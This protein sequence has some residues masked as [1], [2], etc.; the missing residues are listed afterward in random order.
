MCGI[1]GIVDFDGGVVDESLLGRMC[2]AIR[3]RGPDDHGIVRLGGKALDQG[4]ASVG[5]GSRRLSII[6]IAQGQQPMTNEDRTVWVVF[7]GEIYNFADLRQV[8]EQAG[9]TFSTH[10]D[11]EVIVHAYE[12]YGDAFP[13]VLDGMYGFAVW[14]ARRQRL[15]LGRDRF[16]KKP[17]VYAELGSRILFASEL[18]SLLSAPEVPREIDLE[19]MGAY[20]AYMAIPAPLT[21]YRHVRKVPPGHV[22]IHDQQGTRIERY[23]SLDFHSKTTDDPRDAVQR[24]Q[25]L[26][27]DAVRKRLV[28]EVPLG[29]FL[30]GG[31]DSS[32]VVATMASLSDTPVKTFSI[33]FDEPEYDELPH[34]RRVAKAFDCEH[35]ELVVRADAIEM[36]PSLVR[37]FGEPFADS[38][39]I[40]TAYLT[41]LTREHVTVAL[42]G[43]GG[44]ELF[45]GYGRHM[46]SKWVET[47]QRVPVPWGWFAKAADRMAGQAADARRPLARL[48]RVMRA[49]TAE[50][51]AR[52]RNWVGVFD[53]ELLACLGGDLLPDIDPVK[54]EFAQTTDLD[55]VDSMLAVDTAYYLPTDLLVKVDIASMMHSLEA[56][57][58]FLDHK[59]AEYVASLPSNLK[60]RGFFGKAVLKDALRGVVPAENLKR[61][62]RG[63]AVPVARWFKTDLREFLNDHLRPSRVA[64]AGLVRQSV[65][66]EL[67]TKH[68]SGA[69]D[70]GHHLWSLL[71]LELWHRAFMGS[72]SV[73]DN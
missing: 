19:A 54:G 67:I 71:M 35:H 55:A 23:W 13:T 42:N 45:A 31:V 14:D 56:R 2:D 17:L 39:A 53:P 50:R 22:L 51:S 40:P 3:H 37:H 7:N 5:L 8:L 6:D 64:S 72:G 61:E 63:F 12:E 58:P 49:A 25:E 62:K 15:L 36:L 44:D 60:I 41:A 27:T 65:I 48:A 66:D 16:G 29:A 47:W 57:S 18:Q 24:V 73:R 28:S 33:G 69:V 70:Y 46:A 21:I 10:S 20:L 30:S 1:A 4:G 32:A 34:A 38:S 9:H 11:T 52:Y 68:Q 59:L 43:D 26:F